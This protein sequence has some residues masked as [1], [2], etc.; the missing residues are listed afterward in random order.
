[1]TEI[2]YL[3]KLAEVC[4]ADTMDAARRSGT[5]GPWCYA[6]GRSDNV[7]LRPCKCGF[8][9]SFACSKLKNL[10]ADCGKAHEQVADFIERMFAEKNPRVHRVDGRKARKFRFLRDALETLHEQGDVSAKTLRSLL[11]SRCDAWADEPDDFRRNVLEAF[12]RAHFLN[13]R[14]LAAGIEAEENNYSIEKLVSS[15]IFNR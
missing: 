9:E 11:G 14:A 3:K 10:C 8:P 13:F 4:I 15:G 5:T 2:S 12:R 1:M 7:E 6:C